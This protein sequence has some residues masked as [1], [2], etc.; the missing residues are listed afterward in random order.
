MAVLSRDYQKFPLIINGWKLLQNQPWSFCELRMF[1]I[2]NISKQN[3]STV[4]PPYVQPTCRHVNFIITSLNPLY[5]TSIITDVH[6]NVGTLERTLVIDIG[7]NEVWLCP[8]PSFG[9]HRTYSV[10][11]P[12]R[13]WRLVS[14]RSLPVS[15]GD[16]SVRMR[17]VSWRNQWTDDYS[18][19]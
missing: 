13:K 15:S 10:P 19:N 2:S 4:K 14:W 9:K 7:C 1:V 5:Q 3:I 8:K 12:E 16:W 11:I 6:Y 18:I 17:R